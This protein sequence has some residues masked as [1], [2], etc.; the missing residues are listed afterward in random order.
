[1]QEMYKRGSVANLKTTYTVQQVAFAIYILYKES[2]YKEE[3][4]DCGRI[5]T[6]WQYD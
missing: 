1:M 5:Y 2:I 6:E 3:K 4:M